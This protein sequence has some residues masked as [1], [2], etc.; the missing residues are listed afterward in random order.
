T[1]AGVVVVGAAVAACAHADVGAAAAPAA[2]EAGEQEVGGVAAAA[3]DIVAAL[4]QDRLRAGEG[5]LVDERLVL[6]VE[7]LIAP[8]DLAGVGGVGEDEV[9]RRMA[10][11]GRG[12]RCAWS[13]RSRAAI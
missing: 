1:G 5:D 10:P 6:S 8:A 9:H 2:D 12:C 3:R 13:V 7:G 11:A 4:A